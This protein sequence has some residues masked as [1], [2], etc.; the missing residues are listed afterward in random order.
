MAWLYA[1]CAIGASMEGLMGVSDTYAVI[2]SSQVA[3]IHN[4]Q[5]E[6]Y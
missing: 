2:I 1:S 4:V 3:Q 6:C 5:L